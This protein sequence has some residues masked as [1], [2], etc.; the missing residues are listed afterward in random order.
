MSSPLSSEAARAPSPPAL[1]FAVALAAVLA[2]LPGARVTLLR[3]LDGVLFNTVNNIAAP[4]V[5]FFFNGWVH[6]LPELVAHAARG[7]PVAAQMAVYVGFAVIAAAVM[8][9]E[10]FRLLRLFLPARDAILFTLVALIFVQFYVPLLAQLVWS[11]WTIAIAVCCH[12]LRK[13]VADER[14]TTLGFV[15]TV[16]GGV[17]H[18]AAVALI[19]LIGWCAWRSGDE[20][21]RRQSLLLMAVL[22]AFFAA[23]ALLKPSGAHYLSG[24][25]IISSA[26]V[27]WRQWHEAGWHSLPLAL[28]LAVLIWRS[29]RAVM[30]PASRQ[31]TAVLALAYVGCATLGLYLF[32]GRAE[33]SSALPA[34]YTVTPVLAGLAVAAIDGVTRC[35]T[36]R[37]RCAMTAIALLLLVAE[38]ALINLRL[39]GTLDRT[40][41]QVAFARAADDFRRACRANDALLQQA[42]GPRATRNYPFV[43]CQ[44]LDYAALDRLT[45]ERDEYGNLYGMGL[46]ARVWRG[47][48][49]APVELFLP[50]R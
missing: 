50:R 8:L 35:E 38:A 27:V 9:R 45:A 49:T 26:R 23:T 25:P 22:L 14:Y 33:L 13:T 37:W 43:L 41:E 32:T 36:R 42:T 24:N 5:V 3:G 15:A 19:P 40:R 39:G 2:A 11:V 12:V 17:S 4:D 30:A 34:R 44:P 46:Q 29:A 6:L 16:A 20:S 10:Y 18:P 31:R 7:L 48:Q 21:L 28:A 47:E 1:E